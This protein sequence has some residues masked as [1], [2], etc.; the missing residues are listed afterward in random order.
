MLF[1]GHDDD[2]DDDDD[3]NY[4]CIC[5]FLQCVSAAVAPSVDAGKKP[6]NVDKVH[7]TSTGMYEDVRSGVSII[8]QEGGEPIHSCYHVGTWP[9]APPHSTYGWSVVC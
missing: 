1:F 7:H 3:Y 8:S 5:F 4:I 2:D 6:T 9:N